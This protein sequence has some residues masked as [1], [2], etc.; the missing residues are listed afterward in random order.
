MRHRTPASARLDHSVL[1][2]GHFDELPLNGIKST[3]DKS[4]IDR[5]GVI[6][7]HFAAILSIPDNDRI[8]AF[9]GQR[10]KN[11][12]AP[13]S[14]IEFFFAAQRNKTTLLLAMRR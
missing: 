6:I 8:L 10:A 14:G 3:I 9:I 4:T 12:L 13:E 11:V 1:G 2:L 5:S 7:L